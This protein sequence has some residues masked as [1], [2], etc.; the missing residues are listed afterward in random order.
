VSTAPRETWSLRKPAVTG[1]GGLVATQHAGAAEVGAEVLVA[2]GNAV[3]A[4]LAASLALAVLEPWMSGLGGGGWM[5]V[6]RANGAAEATDFGMVAPV[7]LDPAGVSADR[8]SR[9]RAVR[10]ARGPGAAQPARA[11]LDRGA[12][13][14]GGP[15][16]G[17]SSPSTGCSGASR[18]STTAQRRGSSDLWAMP[19]KL[20]R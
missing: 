7:R 3:D 5:M 16:A 6:A 2:G 4:A 10:L 12:G 8:R 1:G 11:G 17:A 9:R 14:G 19:L 20:V 13:P 18:E 15:W